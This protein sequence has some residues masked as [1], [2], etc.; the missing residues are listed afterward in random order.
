MK[1]Y[2]IKIVDCGFSFEELPTLKIDNIY[3]GESH[4]VEAYARIAAGEDA[5]YVNMWTTEPETVAES[6]GIYGYPSMDSCL[7]F[8]F[9]PNEN[10]ERYINVEFNS[11]GCFFFGFASGNTDLMRIAPLREKNLFSP[12]IVTRDGGWEI[13]YR[14]PYELIRRVFPDFEVYEGKRI[15]ANCY[16]CCERGSFSH[17]LTW[18]DSTD[19]TGSFH[20]PKIFGEMIFVK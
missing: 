20:N 16:K 18:N 6:S 8:F 3:K 12:E 1:K 5:L 9:F 17:Y 7:E 11:I 2:E 15:K 19:N 14:V 13:K 10:G 4:G